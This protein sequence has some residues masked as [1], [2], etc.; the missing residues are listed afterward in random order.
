VTHAERVYRVL[1]SSG[2]PVPFLLI[3]SLLADHLTREQVWGAL[4]VLR[5]H[6]KADAIDGVGWHRIIE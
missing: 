6:G 2:N 5:Q 3:A 4:R 1:P